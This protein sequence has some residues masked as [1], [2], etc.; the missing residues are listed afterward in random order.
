MTRMK[1]CGLSS[2]EEVE[3]AAELG[4][5]YV[6]FVV[7]APRSHR[8]LDLERA[9]TLIEEAPVDVRTV[10]VTPTHD[11]DALREAVATCRPDIVQVSGRPPEAA[12]EDVLDEHGLESWKSA[13]LGPDVD[14]TVNEITPLQTV[15]DAVLLDAVE[16]GYGGHGRTID[17]ATAGAVAEEL[18]AFP[19]VLAGGLTPENVTE[20]IRRVGPWCVD[21]SSG[22]ET[23]G[24]K[25]PKQMEAFARAVRETEGTR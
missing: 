2:T 3:Q 12:V 5:G 24:S 19:L 11:G 7:Q 20:A 21:V 17:W 16:D 10:L 25:D 1:F 14:A 13:S 4:A 22:I 9:R 8:D 15:H 23:D 6:G 18:D